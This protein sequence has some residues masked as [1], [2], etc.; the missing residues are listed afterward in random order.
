MK[1]EVQQNSK[2]VNPL[3][4]NLTN[5]RNNFMDFKSDIESK[6]WDYDTT[7]SNLIKQLRERDDDKSKKSDKKISKENLVNLAD[8]ENHD[9]ENE[10][11]KNKLSEIDKNKKNVKF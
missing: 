11:L 6:N 3:N 1:L 7:L 9:K 4:F 2:D 8:K 5:V 10:N